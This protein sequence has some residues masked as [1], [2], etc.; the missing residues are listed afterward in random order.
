MP[1]G[2]NNLVTSYTPQ[3]RRNDFTG[4]VGLGFTPNA[5]MTFNRVGMRCGYGTL[6]PKTVALGTGDGSVWLWTGV[7]D[8]TGG[9]ENDWF[10]VDIPEVTVGPGGPGP[11]WAAYV[12][13]METIASDGYFWATDGASYIC[14]LRNCDTWNSIYGVSGINGPAASLDQSQSMY[15]GLDLD[16]V[17]EAAPASVWST[18]DADLNSF[19]L[20]NNGLTVTPTGA[21]FWRCIRNTISK[22][23]GQWYV[24]FT[25][26]ALLSPYVMWGVA[27]SGFD[28][29]GLP[30]SDYSGSVYP[31]AQ[32]FISSGFT[33]MYGCDLG[34][35]DLNSV[36]ALAVD[37]DAGSMW[38][39]KDNVW[40]GSS[41]PATALSPIITFI[42]ATVGPL[43]I[44]LTLYQDSDTW[45]L[46]A[47]A[48]S[49]TYAPP[50]GFSAWDA[51]G[52]APGG[53][54]VDL[55]GD[56]AV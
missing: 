9:A 13:W 14:A 20:T 49:Q 36:W 40:A 22:A 42:P 55:V 38:I 26:S 50:S 24:E 12:L 47:T 19:A 53:A 1:G 28:P 56:L 48:A 7:I 34:D 21:A 54:T 31:E 33:S 39:A 10:W 37:F 4:V 3:A 16:Y 44:C 41:D 46:Q 30:G 27:S 32:N 5:S 51:S 6:G 23:S 8:V 11:S 15:V 18:A 17:V 45:T 2:P 52:G 35:P 29:T 25:V 43:F